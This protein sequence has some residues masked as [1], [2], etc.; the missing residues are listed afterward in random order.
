MQRHPSQS[1]HYSLRSDLNQHVLRSAKTMAVLRQRRYILDCDVP[2]LMAGDVR[3]RWDLFGSLM[4]TFTLHVLAIPPFLRSSRFPAFHAPH[5]PPHT[6]ALPGSA[7]WPPPS[8]ARPRPPRCRSPARHKDPRC[9]R[10][11][12]TRSARSGGHSFRR[13]SHLAVVNK[14]QMR[15]PCGGLRRRSRMCSRARHQAC[16]QRTWGRRARAGRPG[17]A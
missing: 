11:S 14:V 16:A 1:L 8:L 4:M 5:S 3:T 15:C 12:M 17:A 6:R 9:S 2:L 7:G 13:G 10:V